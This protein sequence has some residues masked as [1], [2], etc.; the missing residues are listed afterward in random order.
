MGI[1]IADA[2]KALTVVAE[3]DQPAGLGIAF[4]PGDLIGESPEM[5]V[6]NPAML[7]GL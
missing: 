7:A 3:L 4:D 2:E 6:F 1:I 5:A